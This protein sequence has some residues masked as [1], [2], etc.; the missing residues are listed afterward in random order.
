M[1][2]WTGALCMEMDVNV[3]NGVYGIGHTVEMRTGDRQMDCNLNWCP[4]AHSLHV[5]GSLC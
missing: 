2:M 3:L 1:G 5:G 4:M